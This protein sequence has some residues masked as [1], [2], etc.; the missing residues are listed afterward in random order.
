[1]EVVVVI[2]STIAKAKKERGTVRCII[3]VIVVVM[4]EQRMSRFLKKQTI[5]SL[6]VM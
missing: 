4:K 1:M 5:K 3:R 6:H 2:I